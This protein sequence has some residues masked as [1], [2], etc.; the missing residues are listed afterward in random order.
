MRTL[1]SILLILAP[2]TAQGEDPAATLDGSQTVPPPSVV[3]TESFEFPSL[4]LAKDNS[5]SD[6][7]SKKQRYA[8][9]TGTIEEWLSPSIVCFSFVDEKTKESKT[10]LGHL[11]GIRP[12]DCVVVP[13]LE[14]GRII[15]Y[16]LPHTG[17]FHVNEDARGSRIVSTAAGIQWRGKSRELNDAIHL[18]QLPSIYIEMKNG[19][20]VNNPIGPYAKLNICVEFAARLAGSGEELF[21]VDLGVLLVAQYGLFA[22]PACGW[23]VEHDPLQ[24]E[25]PANYYAG[26]LSMFSNT[27]VSAMAS[28]D[29]IE[30][31]R[32]YFVRS[33]EFPFAKD[34]KYFMKWLEELRVKDPGQIFTPDGYLNVYA[35][36]KYW[37]TKKIPGEASP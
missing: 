6:P 7:D 31:R 15:N 28:Q 29:H 24:M 22:K 5:L 25:V 1:I 34:A 4:K 8:K 36:Q 16:S 2:W 37:E 30:L 17:F 13:K 19:E 9:V 32:V 23:R 27:I 10:Y 33:L 12:R 21:G 14:G 11:I 18:Y 26:L 35:L 3:L 20:P